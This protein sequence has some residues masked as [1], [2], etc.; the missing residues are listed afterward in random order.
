MA[1]L[2]E[3]DLRNASAGEG[4]PPSARA[5]LL[6]MSLS[7]PPHVFTKAIAF[8]GQ[9]HLFTVAF[10]DSC[11]TCIV[12]GLSTINAVDDNRERLNTVPTPMPHKVSGGS[13]NFC[14]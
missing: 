11:Y 2:C 13:P 10:D 9:S 8:I 7:C 5:L 6:C 4:C 1:D 3:A 14:E 12:S